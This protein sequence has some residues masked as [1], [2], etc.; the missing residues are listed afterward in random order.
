MGSKRAQGM[1]FFS[2]SNLKIKTDKC[3]SSRNTTSGRRSYLRPDII[4][5][6]PRL[7]HKSV[8]HSVIPSPKAC[9]I[10]H[11]YFALQGSPKL[12]FKIKYTTF[13]AFI[14]VLHRDETFVKLDI[15]TFKTFSA[16][17]DGTNLH[18]TFESFSFLG[19]Y[20]I[21]LKINE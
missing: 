2:K 12:F 21:S 13:I 7:L 5:P 18:I 16:S 15:F 20:G 11:G 6:F 3:P 9:N 17:R 19:S 8:Y 14:F 1:K 10:R 4:P